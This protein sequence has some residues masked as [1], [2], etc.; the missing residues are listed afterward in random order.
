MGL[1]QSEALT[2]W[3]ESADTLDH[4]SLSVSSGYDVVKSGPHI[5][6]TG[7]FHLV[8]PDGISTETITMAPSF[9]AGPNSK[10]FFESRLGVATPSQVAEVQ[11]STNDG[12]NW[13]LLWSQ[14][15]LGQPGQSTFHR[16][17][18]DL[19]AWAGETL[20]IRFR[21]RFS[22]GGYYPGT[23]VALGWLID[24]IQF[25]ETYL[26]EPVPYSIGEP[27]GLEQ[28]NLE[29]INRAR[30]SASAE[31]IRLRDTD[32]P[33]VVSAMNSFNVDK[34]LLVEQFGELTETVPPLV[35]NP[36][37]IAAARLHSQDMLDNVFQGHTS[38]ANPPSPN[39]PYDSMGDRISHQGY[40][41]ATAGE[42][43]FAYAKSNWHA[44]AG[45]NIDWGSGSQG[46]IGGMQ[47]PPG[48][49]LSIHNGSFREIGIGIIEGTN[50]SVG[51]MLVTQNFGTSQSMNTP[52]ITGV[53]WRDL[54]GNG[55]YD[56]GEGLGGLEVIVEGERFMAVTST[57]GGFGIPVF[58]DG[59]YTVHFQ[60]PDHP[61]WSGSVQVNGGQN[62]KVDYLWDTVPFYPV[63]APLVTDTTSSGGFTLS[64]SEA[65]SLPL[66]QYSDDLQD[67]FDL[68]EITPENMGGNEY[69]FPLP[70]PPDGARFYRLAFP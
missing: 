37:L 11:I 49:R 56:P 42:N 4:V 2:V 69:Q 47:N 20:R 23:S 3:K 68:P 54:N 10:L 8:H 32:D 31:A 7:V 55:E 64:V 52:F 45:F 46:S 58:A 33:D 67:W 62:V 40:D 34:V 41:F 16:Q 25:G 51:P 70:A 61:D 13:S 27:T 50:D 21:Y 15:G 39:E 43:V 24:D 22:G 30:A 44:H 59:T 14:P 9:L 5:E 19:V 60:S 28:Q 48:H 63:I 38:S 17:E 66:L 1:P 65:Y 53:A 6:G 29:F 26:I 57:S 36:K 35:F 18:I 12:A